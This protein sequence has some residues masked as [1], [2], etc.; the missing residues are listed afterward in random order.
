VSSVCIFFD[1]K[2]AL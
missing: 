2:Q 1:L